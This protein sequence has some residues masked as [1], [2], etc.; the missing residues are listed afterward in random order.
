MLTCGLYD[1]SGTYAARVGLPSKSGV[2]GGLLAVLPGEFTL[3]AWS[4]RLD[5]YGNSAVSN[6]ALERLVEHIGRSPLG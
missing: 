3:C 5:K 1:A 4:P 2:G 6:W